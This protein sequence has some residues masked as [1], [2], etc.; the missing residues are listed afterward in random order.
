MAVAVSVAATVLGGTACVAPAGPSS[1]NVTSSTNATSSV[2]AGGTVAPQTT[3]PGAGLSTLLIQPPG[4]VGVPN[5]QLSG[6]IGRA[7]VG[8]IFVEHPA[9]ATEIVG[10]GFVGGYA[11]SWKQ[12]PATYGAGQTTPPDA[13]VIGGFVLQFDTEEHARTVLSHFRRQNVADGYQFLSVPSQLAEGY[14]VRRGP[15][16]FGLISFGVA[17]VHGVYLVNI[18]FQ[19]TDKAATANQVIALATAQ[20]DALT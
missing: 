11:R 5:D 14:G 20:E 7:D 6:P 8:R 12:P 10:H 16:E 4:F 15:D 18:T 1:T 2:D 13:T 9:D 19:T 3:G 17:W